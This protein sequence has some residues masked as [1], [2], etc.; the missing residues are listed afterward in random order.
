[1]SAR[2][3]VAEGTAKLRAAPDGRLV[4]Y[5]L[6][7]LGGLGAAVVVGEPALAALAA[8]FALALALGLRRTGP[9]AATARVVLDADQVIEGDLVTGRLELEWEGEFDAR[10]MLYRLRG[11][12]AVGDGTSVEGGTPAL[13]GTNPE[14]RPSA[15]AGASVD[16]PTSTEDPPRAEDAPSV[17]DPAPVED[18][19]RAER[20]SPASPDLTSSTLT[21]SWSRLDAGGALE[22]PIRLRAKQWGRHTVGEVWVRLE[23][24]FGLLSWTGRVVHGPV[25]RVLPGSERLTRLLDPAES[26]TVLGV[27]RSRRIGAGHE[28]AELRP[29]VPGD[30]LRDLNWSATAR[31]GRPFVNRRH[32]ALAGEVV[33]AIDA[34]GD[35]ASTG[36]A[37]AL[38]RAARAAWAVASVHLRANDR[39]GLSGLGGSTRWLPPGGGRLARYRLLETLLGIGGD[40]ADPAAIR[41]GPHRPPIPASALVFALTPLQDRQSVETLVAWRARGRAVAVVVIDAIDPFLIGGPARGSEVLA[42]RLWRL[43]RDRRARELA[44]LGI[45]VVVADAGGSIESVVTALRRLRGAPGVRR[46]LA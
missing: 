9:V 39:V 36:S 45:P 1:M 7:A 17:D 12:A 34:F 22:I 8:P 23:V 33:I 32:P 43:E 15:V 24:R 18:P 11:V 10:V 31:H 25:L 35:D 2:P 38:S 28:F 20:D 3:A 40:A 5:G 37:A 41:T 44:E 26:R 29:Y 46:R 27:H 4:P 14:D 6:I 13:D 21:P 16:A 19:G 30:R 42:R